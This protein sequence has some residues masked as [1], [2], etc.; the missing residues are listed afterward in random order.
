MKMMKRWLSCALA[1][2]MLLGLVGCGGGTDEETAFDGD[3]RGFSCGGGEHGLHLGAQ[4]GGGELPAHRATAAD[5]SETVPSYRYA[6][7]SYPK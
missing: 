4:V 1:L 7:M 3:R 6:G 5:A 2:V